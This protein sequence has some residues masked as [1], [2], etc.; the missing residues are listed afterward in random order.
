MQIS[1]RNFTFIHPSIQRR[2]LTIGFSN[3]FPSDI[4]EN[5]LEFSKE[6]HPCLEEIENNPFSGNMNSHLLHYYLYTKISFAH[7]NKFITMWAHDY[8]D[9]LTDSDY[10]MFDFICQE[11]ELIDS[12]NFQFRPVIRDM[13]DLEIYTYIRSLQIREIASKL[14]YEVDILFP[15]ILGDLLDTDAFHKVCI[16]NIIFIFDSQDHLEN[17]EN[18]QHIDL[19]TCVSYYGE[20]SSNS[21]NDILKCS[22]LPEEYKYKL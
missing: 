12:D 4:I 2:V 17:L 13:S 21:K 7:E 15:N 10:D 14:T 1:K 16:G 3:L 19:I 9:C 5:I 22:G 8:I 18:L 11:D 6:K 20:E